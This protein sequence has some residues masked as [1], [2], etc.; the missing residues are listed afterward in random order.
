[1]VGSPHRIK[2]REIILLRSN[3]HR[4][5]SFNLKRILTF[6]ARNLRC[7]EIAKKFEFWERNKNWH[8]TLK[9]SVVVLHDICQ[10]K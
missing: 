5:G 10:K 7:L 3:S 6:A 8:S 2:G 1:M 9:Y 4:Q